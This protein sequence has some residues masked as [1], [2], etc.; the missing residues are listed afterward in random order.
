M[1]DDDPFSSPDPADRDPPDVSDSGQFPS[2]DGDPPV[3][4]ED[5]AVDYTDGGTVAGD[6]VDCRN[7]AHKQVCTMFEGLAPQL[8][9]YSEDGRV[10]GDGHQ[11]Q[12]QA[13][14]EDVDGDIEPID[15]HDLAI[16]CSEFLHVEEVQ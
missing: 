2:F 15:P 7:C 3:D 9:D 8:V 1:T 4:G 11:Q 14:P 16:I 5:D 13:R 6:D 10:S 12:Q